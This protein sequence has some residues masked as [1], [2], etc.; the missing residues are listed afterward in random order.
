MKRMI[1]KRKR[2]MYSGLILLLY[3]CFFPLLLKAELTLNTRQMSVSQTINTNDLFKSPALKAF[4][5][6]SP[7]KIIQTY[8]DGAAKGD[9][10]LKDEGKPYTSF[11]Q[12]FVRILY[13]FT[14]MKEG[15]DATMSVLAP[16]FLLF[17]LVSILPFAFK[18]LFVPPN[19]ENPQ[20]PEND[21]IKRR[22]FRRR[23]KKPSKDE[24]EEE[25]KN[26]YD[27]EEDLV[28]DEDMAEDD[29]DNEEDRS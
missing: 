25:E 17:F 12:F 21:T 15:P 26:E 11:K 19:M 4:Q 10:W 28:S 14:M 13:W 24:N 23:K 22:W 7:E 18:A 3:L 29:T 8:K 2:I 27:E 9:K 6:L 16:F 1:G 5:G 20:R